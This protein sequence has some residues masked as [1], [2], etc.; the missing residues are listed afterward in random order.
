MIGL[1]RSRAFLLSLGESAAVENT[2]ETMSNA[3]SAGTVYW[4]D[5]FV[6]PVNDL[7]RWRSFMTDVFGG[8]FEH[9]G[10]LTT[11]AR[12]QRAPIRTFFAVGHYHHIGGFL[13]EQVLPPPSALGAGMP[14]HAFYIRA[15]DIDAHLRRLDA[16]GVPYAGP[17]A[18]SENGEDGTAIY[19][20]DHD[21][22]QYEFWAPKIQPPGAMENDNP[23]RV[24]R[25]S[26]VVLESLDLKRA[27]EYYRRYCGLEPIVNDDVAA[28]TLAL[29][30]A[31]GGRMIFK[32]VAA[33]SPRTGGH[34]LWK[35]QHVALTVGDEKF[36]DAYRQLWSG[37]PESE[38]LPYSGDAI[39]IDER[40]LPPRT[41]LHGRQARG[42][43][44]NSLGRGTFF[45]DWDGNNFHFVGGR[46]L[47]PNYAHYIAGKDE[48]F[49]FPAAV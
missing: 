35:G 4:I 1:G 32:R 30:L 22:N 48:N 10:G 42:E 27:A 20:A 40:T 19:F 11:A 12:A 33:H 44:K 29:R 41:E 24:G 36:I 2:G 9:E 28:G 8:R 34:N 43:Q 45:Y 31:S 3:A 14:R 15:G 26:H 49:T 13:Q 47:D 46:P 18:T 21:G 38:Y 25:I 7:P 37:L 39:A 16:A 23:S 17:E 6:V 5:H